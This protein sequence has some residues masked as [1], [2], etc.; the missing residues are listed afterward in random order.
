MPYGTWDD[1]EI[2]TQ[3]KD[4][5]FTSTMP[6]DTGHVDSLTWLKTLGFLPII[7][8]GGGIIYF[9]RRRKKI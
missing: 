9:A 4:T 1:T 6:S 8:I 5:M 3:G 7:A 2:N